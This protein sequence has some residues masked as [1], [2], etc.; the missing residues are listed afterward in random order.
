[1]RAPDQ[2]ARDRA[3]DPSRS[4]A[5]VAPAGSGKTSLL[6]LRMLKLL[7]QV[8]SPEALLA[9]T[10]TRKAAGEMRTRIAKALRSVD[11]AEPKNAYERAL[12]EA[13]K[14][15]ARRHPEL[16]EQPSR[17]SILTFDALAYAI[18]QRAPLAAGPLAGLAPTEHADLLYKQA[19]YA[20]IDALQGT[21]IWSQ[22]LSVADGAPSWLV[23][24]VC[25]WLGR[26]DQVEL[27]FADGMPDDPER[28][29]AFLLQ[30]S[31]ALL[32][33]WAENLVEK[34]DD[35]R[36]AELIRRAAQGRIAYRREKG[37]PID[38]LWVPLAD[39][40]WQ[41]D[42][43]DWRLFHAGVGLLFT[44]NGFRKD[45]TGR[46]K[47]AFAKEE[48][49]EVKALAE[50]IA[51]DGEIVSLL[52]EVRSL[53]GAIAYSEEERAAF[54]AMMHLFFEAKKQLHSVFARAGK[55]D[56]VEIGLGAIR[57][58][59]SAEEGASDLLLG[60]DARL[61]HVL[62]DEFQDTSRWQVALLAR[63][64]AGFDGR[65][66]TL[67]VV[68]DPMQS[69][70][71]FRKAD[72][73]IFLGLLDAAAK[74]MP[75]FGLPAMERVQLT[76]N[77]RSASPLV[78]AFNR[79]LPQLAPQPDLVIEAKAASGREKGAL[80]LILGKEM[81]RD[82]EVEQAFCE[83]MRLR[84]ELGVQA[85]IA[86]LARDRKWLRP[87]AA[88]LREEGVRFRAVGLETMA[89]AVPVRWLRA[90][91]ELSI[92]PGSAAAWASLLRAPFVGLDVDA[93]AQLQ[94]AIEGDWDA[95]AVRDAA[96]ALADPTLRRRVLRFVDAI[97]AFF[98]ELA[99]RPVAAAIERALMRLGAFSALDAELGRTLGS[100][101]DLVAELEKVGE[102][103]LAAFDAA[104]GNLYAEPDAS[105]EAGRLVLSTIH[106]AKGLE[107][108]GV[109]LFGLGDSPNSDQER[110]VWTTLVRGDAEYPIL[111]LA[112]FRRGEA[113][114]LGF[115][116]GIEKQAQSNEHKRLFYVG[117]TRARTELVLIGSLTKTGKA[118]S[119]SMLSFLGGNE[120]EI[121]AL[122]GC[123]AQ[124]IEEGE[125]EEAVL[126]SELS[127]WAVEVSD[128]PSAAQPMA[129]PLYA[130]ASVVQPAIGEAVHRLLM[131]V[132]KLGIE[133]W[134][135]EGRNAR[136]LLQR[137]LRRAGVSASEMASALRRAE[138]AWLKMQQSERGRW[139]LSNEGKEDPRCEWE[140]IGRIGDRI[141]RRRIDRSFV[142]DG[143]R[144]IVD[145][146]TAAHAG[147]E[148]DAFLE[149]EK[150]RYRAQLAEY[151]RLV[152]MLDPSRP[153]K[154]ALYFPL[155]DA[156]C[157]LD[158]APEQA[159]S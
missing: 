140:L 152:R 78:A 115:V 52:R 81:S 83:L 22:A 84:K 111:G 106:G 147:G 132:A 110:F 136:D 72:V 66:R 14:E 5:V 125:S 26:R 27:L 102:L 150:Q 139:L 76:A 91:V 137:A 86:A 68:G 113:E 54:G 49:K 59:G 105:E 10:F 34:L 46:S 92:E 21:E 36:L 135:A 142:V 143:V 138:E 96:E 35:P 151:A 133:R 120:E 80:K 13:A 28:A 31:E 43:S 149:Q 148:L 9:I 100:A 29:A 40:A 93:L 3:I 7:A 62:V 157:E 20:A 11:R 130:W 58:L 33:A 17:L 88:R 53:P 104:L 2:Q 122:L 82:A 85:T 146:K 47:F 155:L 97:E 95:K 19:A 44:K 128:T 56:F 131:E 75:C 118:P 37:E 38:P 48:R 18:V 24:Q 124:A 12:L 71:R 60:L 141:V 41:A 126:S 145:Y 117:C 127:R 6:V 79:M 1:M 101:C 65:E 61:A 15:A 42:V 116:R 94:A 39:G 158:A 112:S 87:L 70:Y 57:A 103:S 109:V 4:C 119:G 108:D 51:A 156:F 134:Q 63:L 90:L 77:F 99:H 32:R 67:F 123:E 8:E 73:E 45:W 98:A 16:A 50:E 23:D 25:H 55:V 69:I 153:I 89:E 121:A 129:P 114:M 154:T 144:W 159:R 107:W 64:V 30:R 74:G